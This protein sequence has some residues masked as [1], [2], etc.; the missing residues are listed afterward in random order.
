MKNN[1]FG[2]LAIMLRER[3]YERRPKTRV[4]KFSLGLPSE[5]KLMHL[6][7][8]CASFAQVSRKLIIITRKIVAARVS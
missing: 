8:V 6:A 4:M 1:F 7:Q 3:I 5:V 2:V